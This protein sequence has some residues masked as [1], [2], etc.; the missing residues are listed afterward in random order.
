MLQTKYK[1]TINPM[2]SSASI[3]FETT[4]QPTN[5]LKSSRDSTLASTSSEFKLTQLTTRFDSTQNSVQTQHNSLCNLYYILGWVLLSSTDAATI[6]CCF[7]CCCCSYC[8]TV[9][10]YPGLVCFTGDD[11]DDDHGD[12]DDDDGG[13]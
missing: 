1:L 6:C 7:C 5:Q 11:S 8:F 12:D 2:S 13:S 10:L 3:L 9:A 4:N